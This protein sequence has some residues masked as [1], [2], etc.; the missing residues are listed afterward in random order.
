MKKSQI[1]ELIR[2]IVR[3]VL[4]EYTTTSTTSTGTDASIPTGLDSTLTPAEKSK[5]E[6][7]AERAKLKNIR[8]ID[9]D[10]KNTKNQS[11]YFAG[12]KKQNDLKVQA[13]EKERQNL[14]ADKTISTGGAGSVNP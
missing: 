5:Q 2:G 9:M 14:K 6:R 3:Q 11:T 10:I 12:Q 13:Q 1:Q 8:S 4:K 7:E